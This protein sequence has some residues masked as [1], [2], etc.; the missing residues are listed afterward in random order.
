MNESEL[1]MFVKHIIC[2]INEAKELK[3]KKKNEKLDEMI[4]FCIE[5]PKIHRMIFKQ[6]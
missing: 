5:I 3:G 6:I 4:Q 1:N 2:G